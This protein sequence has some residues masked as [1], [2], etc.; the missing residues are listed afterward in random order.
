MQR[1][2]GDQCS[3]DRENNQLGVLAGVIILNSD[4][5]ERKHHCYS[6]VKISQRN[7]DPVGAEETSLL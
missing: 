1:P 7:R 6:S 3:L 5:L 4:V 2:L